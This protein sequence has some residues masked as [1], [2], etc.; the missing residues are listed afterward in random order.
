MHLHLILTS[1][2]RITRDVLVLLPSGLGYYIWQ[3]EIREFDFLKLNS[4]SQILRFFDKGL[5]VVTHSS[6]LSV[7]CINPL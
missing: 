1:S 5:S 4:L 6:R 7:I 3:F 2:V